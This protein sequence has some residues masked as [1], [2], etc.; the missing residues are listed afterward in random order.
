MDNAGR[1]DAYRVA[2]MAHAPPGRRLVTVA[3]VAK[4]RMFAGSAQ[5]TTLA[6][7]F[8]LWLLLLRG[9]VRGHVGTTINA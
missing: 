7:G 1:G 2:Q 3:R 6:R 4:V 5:N 9:D 8:W